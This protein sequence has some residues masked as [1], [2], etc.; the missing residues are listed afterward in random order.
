MQ[1]QHT[2]VT[3]IGT[4][5]RPQPR[6]H[7]APKPYDLLPLVD[8]LREALGYLYSRDISSCVRKTHDVFG[9]VTLAQMADPKAPLF[10]GLRDLAFQLEDALDA[11]VQALEAGAR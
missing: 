4:K 5:T 9:E 6:K 10:L 3:P 1:R 8:V 2:A 7:P 11:A